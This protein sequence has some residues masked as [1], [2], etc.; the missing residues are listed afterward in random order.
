VT[1]VSFFILQMNILVVREIFKFYVSVLKST[2]MD[3]MN[4]KPDPVTKTQKLNSE[5]NLHMVPRQQVS[6]G[7]LPEGFNISALPVKIF[8]AHSN[9]INHF[10]TLDVPIDC[11]LL[12]KS[13]ASLRSVLQEPFLF[14]ILLVQLM[15]CHGKANPCD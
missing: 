9:S 1:I 12:T 4:L 2:I 3:S 7:T 15:H 14:E 11:H 8:L 13:L 6:L 10:Q 5:T